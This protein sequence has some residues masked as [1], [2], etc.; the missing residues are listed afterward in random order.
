VAT[1]KICPRCGST[2]VPIVRGPGD[3]LCPACNNTGRT[4]QAVAPPQQQWAQVG[5]PQPQYVVQETAPGATVALVTGIASFFPYLGLISAFFALYYSSQA[6]RAIAANPGRYSGSG[7]AQAG[8][9]L[10]IIALCFYGAV[11][12]FLLLIFGV[13]SRMDRF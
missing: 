10:G 9:V 7:M 4:A 8:R 11:L 2:V 13:F 12:V 5:P 6:L 1:L 3:L